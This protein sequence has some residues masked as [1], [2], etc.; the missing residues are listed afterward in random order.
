MKIH[1]QNE[2]TAEN[3]KSEYS[4]GW[5]LFGKKNKILKVAI[6]IIWNAQS[7][8]NSSPRLTPGWVV[9]FKDHKGCLHTFKGYHPM[10]WSLFSWLSFLKL[11]FPRGT[12]IMKNHQITENEPIPLTCC[13]FEDNTWYVKQ[14]EVQNWVTGASR[15]KDLYWSIQRE[16]LA[17]W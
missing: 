3:G 15:C 13:S 14:A 12:V 10:W 4:L 9:H 1:F 6:G 16:W 5:N 17:L 7:F 11:S 8:H 2:H